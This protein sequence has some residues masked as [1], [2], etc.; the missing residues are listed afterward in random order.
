MLE[1]TFFRL[2]FRPPDDD[3]PP[4]C[5]P[6]PLARQGVWRRGQHFDDRNYSGGAALRA[7]NG[8]TDHH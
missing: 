5:R 3:P 7:L 6:L 1:Q 8:S 4:N 2:K